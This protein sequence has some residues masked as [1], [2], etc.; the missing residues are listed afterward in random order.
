MKSSVRLSSLLAKNHRAASGVQSCPKRPEQNEEGWISMVYSLILFFH[1]PF[2]WEKK[3]K[4]WRGRVQCRIFQRR[5]VLS[6]RHNL[7]K[8]LTAIQDKCRDCGDNRSDNTVNVDVQTRLRRPRLAHASAK[9]TP[10]CERE[11]A[12]DWII[13][14]K[15]KNSCVSQPPRAKERGARRDRGCEEGWERGETQAGGF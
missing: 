14:E 2:N 1:L 3:K 13:Q 8:A 11:C 10:D 6:Y 9:T 5:N 15:A 7:G 12:A 4:K